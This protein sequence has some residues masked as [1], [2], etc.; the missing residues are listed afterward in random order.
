[1]SWLETVSVKG[2]EDE[3]AYIIK[4]AREDIDTKDL[5]AA[6]YYLGNC[7]EILEELDRRGEEDE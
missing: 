1:M 7:E 4:C 6:I 5:R 2:L 3:L